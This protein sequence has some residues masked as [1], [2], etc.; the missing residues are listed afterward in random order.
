VPQ[1]VG[2]RCHDC[3]IK[4]E[5]SQNGSDLGR[6]PKARRPKDIA[7][8]FRPR[9]GIKVSLVKPLP[10]EAGDQ[11]ELSPSPSEEQQCKPS[12]DM[13]RQAA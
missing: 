8:I 11:I 9:K 4:L 5:L 12:K 3:W 2:C 1:P 10:I 6:I 13:L 7:V